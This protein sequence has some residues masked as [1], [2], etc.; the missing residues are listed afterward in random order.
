MKTDK[1]RITRYNTLRKVV[2][3][4]VAGVVL[5]MLL[6]GCYWTPGESEGA[7]SLR[8][9]PSGDSISSQELES[10]GIL[11]AYVMDESILRSSPEEAE[12]FFRE[13]DKDEL[14]RQIEAVEEDFSS[15]RFDVSF[16]PAQF[17]H[18]M[19]DYQTDAGGT[20][21]FSGLN[22]GAN[23]L[24]VVQR[25]GIPDGEEL[26]IGSDVVTVRSGE[27]RTANL[28]LGS[29]FTKFD[30]F[31]KER[32][33]VDLLSGFYS[34]IE[35]EFDIASTYL[36]RLSEDE[37]INDDGSLIPEG[38]VILYETRN[39]YFGKMAV[40]ENNA[41]GGL[42]IVFTTYDGN[43]VIAGFDETANIGGTNTFDLEGT[44]A[45]TDFWL[46]N[47]TATERSLNPQNGARFFVVG[48]DSQVMIDF[49]S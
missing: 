20:N 14:R 23:Y 31:I 8:I 6:A 12:R 5:A 35:S 41:G 9:T 32:Y 13:V 19:I 11:L 15:F 30:E 39:G 26:D 36:T 3:V 46:Q 10:S 40:L 21:T 1:S 42:E 38:T 33:G 24:V 16:P 18:A 25:F 22:A 7:I 49:S 27:S 28:E 45:S 43:D 47:K 17:Q 4:P 2:L 37:I 29:D 34:T 48:V 44:N